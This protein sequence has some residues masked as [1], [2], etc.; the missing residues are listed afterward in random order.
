M[1]VPVRR[2]Q[3]VRS[4]PLERWEPFREFEQLHE[5]MGR[6]MEGFTAPLGM[7]NGGAWAPFADIEETEDAWVIEA[8]VPGV[9]RDDVHVELRDDE[10][11]ISGDV[12]QGER[13][14][15]LA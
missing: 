12:Q 2:S 13:R 5:Q 6:L 1:P 11:V 3:D 14:G 15:R 4:Q 10:L 7:T 8:E 9:N